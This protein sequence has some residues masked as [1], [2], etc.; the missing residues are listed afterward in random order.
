MQNFQIYCV[1]ILLSLEY[2]EVFNRA[3]DKS[4]D[5]DSVDTD[6]WLADESVSIW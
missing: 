5:S 4:D 6:T 2:Q 1:Y 3:I